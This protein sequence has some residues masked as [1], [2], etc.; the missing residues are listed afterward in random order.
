MEGETSEREA[1]MEGKCAWRGAGERGEGAASER[2]EKQEREKRQ[3]QTDGRTASRSGGTP[4]TLK[5]A[6]WTGHEAERRDVTPRE[7]PRPW[8]DRREGPRWPQGFAPLAPA[9][10]LPELSLGQRQNFSPSPALLGPVLKRGSP[11]RGTGTW[12]PAPHLQLLCVSSDREG[13]Q[14][15]EERERET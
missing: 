15:S 10:P 12:S 6:A 5:A 4:G 7:G 13:R 9:A 2:E 8:A 14:T 3:L 11:G 1:R